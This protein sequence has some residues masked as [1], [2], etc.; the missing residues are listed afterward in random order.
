MSR[1]RLCIPGSH[2]AMLLA[3]KSTKGVF[4]WMDELDY[5][6]SRVSIER[7]PV[8][9]ATLEPCMIE[10]RRVKEAGDS[11]ERSATLQGKPPRGVN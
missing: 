4:S 11:D 5:T 1:E 9:A 3:H 8:Q 6:S 2:D 7:Q 10:R